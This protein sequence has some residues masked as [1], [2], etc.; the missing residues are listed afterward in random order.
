VPTI[1]DAKPLEDVGAIE[2]L[3]TR[4]AEKTPGRG[5]TWNAGSPADVPLDSMVTSREKYVPLHEMAPDGG[6]P[7]VMGYRDGVALGYQYGFADPL[8][9]YRLDIGVSVSVDGDTPSDEKLHATIDFRTLDWHARY[10]HN[11]ADFYDLFGRR[12]ARARATR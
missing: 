5:K 2:F 12:S 9:L 10:W 3:G 8:H 11:L 6:Y 4:I 7:I 1:I